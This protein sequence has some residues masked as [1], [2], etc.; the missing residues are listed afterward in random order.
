MNN[1]EVVYWDVDGTLADTEMYGHRIAFNNA[2]IEAGLEWH[3][4]I[5]TYTKLLEVSG[6]LRRI[7]Y[8]SEKINY[9]LSDQEIRKLHISKQKYYKEI[10]HSGI[11]PLRTG[12]VRLMNELKDNNIKQWIVTTSS[13]IAVE[14]LYESVLKPLK[15]NIEGCITS[16]DV[17]ITK[18]DPQAYN[19]ACLRSNVDK[20]KSIAIED[21]SI[22][23]Q[24]AKAAG[25]NCLITYSPWN[26]IDLNDYNK[27]NAIVDMLGDENH[28]CSILLGPS[29]RRNVVDLE[30]LTMLIN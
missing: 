28:K 27:A 26:Q 8:F 17:N 11:I 10:L 25:L 6:G 30:Y 16:E 18:P 7:K 9:S 21:S 19:K 12:V 2:F 20:S 15:N 3:W 23:L 13:R 14:A 22:G 4:D 5:P 29:F 24:S 1:L